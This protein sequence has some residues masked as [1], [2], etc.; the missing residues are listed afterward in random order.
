MVK[1]FQLRAYDFIHQITI[2]LPTLT[3]FTLIIYYKNLIF[4]C[5][6]SFAFFFVADFKNSIP[7]LRCDSVSDLYLVISLTR[8]ATLGYNV[9]HNHL[10]HPNSSIFYSL[11]RNKFIGSEHVKSKTI[12]DSCVF[13]KHVMF[14]FVPSN[15]ST[16][17]PF[18]ILHNDLW[19][20][21]I[22]NSF[23]HRYYVLFLND[24]FDFLW[25]FHLGTKSQVFER[26]T[27]LTN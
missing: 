14:P 17:M 23:S 15:N 4:G 7:I 13:G 22:L 10:G 5:F 24:Y 12:M 26:S 2:N 21:L 6:D 19:T 9:W 20:S 3:T 25:V 16:L 8:F 11:H 1:I 18:Y 27:Y